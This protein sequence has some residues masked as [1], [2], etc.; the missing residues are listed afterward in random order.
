MMIGSVRGG[1]EA[2]I[3]LVQTCKAIGVDPKTY[4]NDVLE[5][6]AKESNVTKCTPRG[7]RK[8]FAAEV[9]AARDVLLTKLATA[10]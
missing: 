4:L 1:Q 8:H 6:I 3:L 5:R 7:W 9:A 10:S 2:A